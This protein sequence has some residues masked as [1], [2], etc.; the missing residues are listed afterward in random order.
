MVVKMTVETEIRDLVDKVNSK[1]ERHPEIRE[2]VEN[3][4]KSVN[5]DLGDEKYSF[6]FENAKVE[7]LRTELIDG[8]DI[9]MKTTAE[10][11]VDLINGDLSPM[12][13]FVTGKVKLNGKFQ[14]LMFLKKFF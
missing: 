6:R 13:A 9:T 7:D 1:I 14:D 10:N 2:E 3:I 5:I 8:A 11:F 4:R 12:K